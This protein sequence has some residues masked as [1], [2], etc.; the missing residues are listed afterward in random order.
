MLNIETIQYLVNYFKS[1]VMLMGKSDFAVNSYR[2]NTYELVK[3][4]QLGYYEVKVVEKLL[5][6]EN[7]D[8][9]KWTITN[10]K[11]SQFDKSLQ[12]LLPFG[13]DCISALDK[14]KE[15]KKERVVDE[16]IIEILQIMY[17]QDGCS[18][19]EKKPL[20]TIIE[21]KKAEEKSKQAQEELKRRRQ[22]E[23]ARYTTTYDSCRSGGSFGGG[24]SC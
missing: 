11:L 6:M 10:K 3:I 13:F 21:K 16:S 23:Q 15:L 4:R 19:I 5:G 1:T 20:V 9:L 22:L 24:R 7:T 12:Y 18:K 17:A 2:E 14:I 8:T